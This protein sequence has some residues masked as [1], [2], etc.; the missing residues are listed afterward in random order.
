MGRSIAAALP[1][2][3]PAA[4]IRWGS[5]GPLLVMA[6]AIMGCPG[7]ATAS[8]TAAGSAF[9]VRRSLGYLIGITATLLA[10][11]HQE[12]PQLWT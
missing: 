6:L 9:G 2:P 1:E 5:I 10:V 12:T 7:L 8:L 11:L 3:L 4:T